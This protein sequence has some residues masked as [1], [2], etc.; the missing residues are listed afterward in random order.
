MASEKNN[1]P[2]DSERWK[3]RRSPALEAVIGERVV[4]V[5]GEPDPHGYVTVRGT[6]TSRNGRTST[7]TTRVRTELFVK[8]YFRVREASAT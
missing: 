5:I 4:T 1:V 3:L 6:S 8:A 2:H 7:R